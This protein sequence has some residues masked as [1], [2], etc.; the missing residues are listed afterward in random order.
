MGLTLQK[1][2]S[3]PNV[4]V[5]IAFLSIIIP[6]FLFFVDDD[7]YVKQMYDERNDNRFDQQ[8][9]ERSRIGTMRINDSSTTRSRILLY[10]WIKNNR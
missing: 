8:K 5:V 10:Q 4:K 7:I 2:N 3:L 9:G 1:S 6:M